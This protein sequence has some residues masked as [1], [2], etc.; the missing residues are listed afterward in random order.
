MHYMCLGERQSRICHLA[1]ARHPIASDRGKRLKLLAFVFPFQRPLALPLIEVLVVLAIL[2][3]KAAF[4]EEHASSFDR[5]IAPLL[6]RKC[7]DCHN[8]SAKKGGL[9]LTN[10]DSALAGGESGRVVIPGKPN[11]SLIWQYIDD[12]DMPPDDPLSA[13]EKLLLRNWIASGANWGAGPIDRYRYSTDRRAGYDWW[14][15]QPVRRPRLPATENQ[16][17]A[18]NPIDSFV[19]SKLEERGLSPS[20]LASRRTLILRLTYD[21]TGLPP[22]PEEVAEFEDCRNA[23]A[24][25]RLVD[26]SLSSPH[27]GERW[28]RHWLDIVRFGESQ[29]FERDKLRDNSWQYRDWVVTSLNNDLPYDDFARLQLAGDVLDP[30]SPQAIIATGMLVAG[31][32]DE[33]GQNQQS[34]AMKAVVRQD[35]LEDIVSTVGQTFLGLTV[36]CARCHDHKFDPIRQRE[37][38]QLTA[39]LAGVRHGERDLPGNSARPLAMQQAAAVQAQIDVVVS[40]IESMEN[41]VRNAILVERDRKRRKTKPPT[42]VARWDFNE[43]LRDASGSL[44][45]EFRGGARIGEGRLIVDGKTGYVA[46]APLA[47]DLR[48]KTLEA[49]VKLDNLS[50]RGGGVIS[51]QTLN[52]VVFDAIVFGEREP[53][54][55]M[56]GSNTF[57]RTKSFGGTD[58]QDA[59][60]AFVHVAIVYDED[61]RI[62]GYRNGQPYGKPYKSSGPVTFSAGKSQVVFG[63]RHGEPGGNRM[64]SGSID[65]AQLYDR[66]LTAAEVA[67]SAGVQS[68]HVSAHEIAARLTESDRLRL[69]HLR[70]EL[71]QLQTQKRRSSSMKVYAVAPRTPGPS[72]LLLRGNPA[73]KGD[74]VRPGGVAAL[75]GVQPDFGLPPD[76]SDSDRR[77]QLAKWISD[78]RNPL[79]ARVIVNRLWHYHFGTGLVETPSDFGFNGGRPSHPKLLDWLAAELVEHDFSVKY[80]QRLILTSTTYRQSSQYRQRLAKID[81][82]NRLLWRKSP[83]RVEAETLR[84]SILAVSG[85]LNQTVGGPGFRDFTTFQRNSQFYEML[86][87][88]GDSFNRRSIYR[89]WIRSGRSRFLDVFDCPDPSAKAPRRVVTT[90]P[91]QALSLMNNSFVMRMANNYAER[92]KVDSPEDSSRQAQL[93]YQLAFGR[94][95]DEAEF[96]ASK[97]FIMS[98]GLTAFCRVVL[99]SNEFVY[100]D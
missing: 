54:R 74:V 37:Y 1:Q 63:L 43:D 28:A 55:W 44:H 53:K 24:Y 93:V 11:D 80:I 94:N 87:P 23:N 71:E 42:P 73:A 86:D 26:R 75:Q 41:P 20:N 96:A 61:G 2:S 8:P 12:G 99:N 40:Q 25:E 9:D 38:Y 48:A 65:R 60:D 47:F 85:Q 45:G 14:S 64:L 91:L 100:V 84:D 10:H 90:T 34:A 70:F 89:S 39:A 50:Q 19:L 76:A 95:P 18:T 15:L 83:R 49:W 57:Q 79:F 17:W 58:E 6:A 82:G 32:Y 51:V 36:N 7:L 29:G 31:P 3:L 56:A 33:V 92:V 68:T 67:A 13:S 59:D 78:R 88:V 66:A 98:H 46:T 97:Q 52:G 35:E 72:H 81:A 62:T 4:A 21:L 27:Y 5:K 77:K 30:G 16:A 22:T 69:Q